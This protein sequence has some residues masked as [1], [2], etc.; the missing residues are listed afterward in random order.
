MID[1]RL[2][3]TPRTIILCKVRLNFNLIVLGVINMESR[4]VQ[5]RI[6]SKDGALEDVEIIES[7]CINGCTTYVVRLS[8]GVKCE[9]IFNPFVCQYYADDI[10]AVIKE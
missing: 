7:K 3:L 2:N 6:H 1:L 8:N 9:A 4:K 5:A 10:Y